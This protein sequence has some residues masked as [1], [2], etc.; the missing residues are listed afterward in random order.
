LNDN[1]DKN[2]RIKTLFDEWN[3]IFGDIYGKTETDFTEFTDDLIKMYSLPKNIN[4]RNTLFVLQTYYSIVIKLLIHNLLESLT[5]PTETAKKPIYKSELT[6]LFSG[7]HYT[8]YYIEN[9]F[10][11]HFFEWFIL[12]EDL[13]MNFIHEIISELDTFELQ[14]QLL[15]P[16][17]L[18][19]Y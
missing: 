1:V 10:E 18:E 7:N 19:M 8:N 11:I 6:S 12:S 17:L 3:R 5:N 2:T 14:L 9:F 4:I 13:E 16:K 15:N